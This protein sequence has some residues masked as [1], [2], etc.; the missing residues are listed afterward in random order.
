MGK[1]NPESRKFYFLLDK[2]AYMPNSCWGSN[3]YRKYAIM[4]N[5]TGNTPKIIKDTKE[6]MVLEVYDRIHCGSTPRS[7][8]VELY[9]QLREKVDMLNEQE[10]YLF[11]TP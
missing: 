8:G 7:F 6:H 2:K 9:N 3:A 4:C 10:Y 11:H 5:T 1:L